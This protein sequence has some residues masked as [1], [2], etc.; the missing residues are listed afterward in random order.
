MS[1]GISQFVLCSS[2]IFFFFAHRQPDQAS[3]NLRQL[4][5]F[6]ASPACP[7]ATSSIIY[8]DIT[9]NLVS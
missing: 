2:V 8:V 5:G 9:G 1:K 3:W 7:L 4:F 6:G